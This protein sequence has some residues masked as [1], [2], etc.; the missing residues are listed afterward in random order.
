MSRRAYRLHPACRVR[1]EKFGLLFY[2]LR[3]PKL[4]FAETGE[5]LP[6]NFFSDLSVQGTFWDGAGLAT[7]QRLDTFIGKLVRGGFVNEQSIC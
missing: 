2:D 7:R 1:K 5:L 4:L 6:E 3:G